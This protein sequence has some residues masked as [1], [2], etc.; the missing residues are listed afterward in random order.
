MVKRLETEVWNLE[1]CS[2]CGMCVAACSKQVLGWNGESH[3]VVQSR[4]KT[5]GLSKTTLD[6][7]TFCRKF[8]E[9]VCPRLEHWMPIEAESIQ[10]VRARGPVFSGSPN[11]VIRAVVSAGRSAGL[12][13]GVIM[14]DLERWSLKPVARIATTVEQIVDTVGPQYLWAPLFDVLNE[15]VFEHKMQNIAVIGTPCTAQAV[16]K[17]RASANPLL[18]PYQD[19]IRLSVAV[20][21]T[22]VYRPEMIE[23]VLVKR[24][25]VARDQVRRMEISPD[26]QWLQVTLWDSSV[27]TIQRQ[28]AESFTRAGCG[29][30]DD[31]L[32]ESADLAVGSLGAPAEASTLISRSQAGAIFTRNAVQLGLLETSP[33]VDRQALEA[34]ASEKDRRERAQAFKDLEILMLDGLVDPKKRSDAIQQFIRL[35]RTPVRPGAVE[36]TPRGCTGC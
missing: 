1:N 27:R 20:F 22:G 28:Q 13:D 26:R 8:C 9:E 16:R 6:S 17:L 18:K 31:F 5:L 19:A 12:L 11:D 10:A 35:Y 7:C 29:K 25:G 36:T 3:P 34:A 24:M 23:E 4:T 32:G 33:E 21:C 15:A 14:L 30:C 2:G